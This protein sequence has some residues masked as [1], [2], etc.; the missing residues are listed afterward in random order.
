M[1]NPYNAPEISVQELAQRLENGEPLIILDVREPYE[2]AAASLPEDKIILVPLSQLATQQLAVLPSEVQS[3]ETE[4]AVLCH[5]G[6]RS[7]QVTVWLRQQGWIHVFSVAGGIDAY[8]RE[9]DSS[10]G[11]Y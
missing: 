4:I 9:V 10:V 1:T 7:A 11:T 5:H 6:V 2:L 3:K 8:A